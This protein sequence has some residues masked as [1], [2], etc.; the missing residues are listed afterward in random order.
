M[1]GNT[2]Q[3]ASAISNF[4]DDGPIR[5]TVGTTLLLHWLELELWL[6]LPSSSES[7][8]FDVLLFLLE[9]SRVILMSKLGEH[10]L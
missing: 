1:T 10:A 8:P 9:T 7:S 2:S 6:S 4:V 3:Q 5:M